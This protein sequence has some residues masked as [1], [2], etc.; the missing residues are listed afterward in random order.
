MNNSSA[1]LRT[2]KPEVTAGNCQRITVIVMLVFSSSHSVLL[3]VGT[4][5]PRK[6]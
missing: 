2:L 4:V 1:D 5:C 6:N 3:T